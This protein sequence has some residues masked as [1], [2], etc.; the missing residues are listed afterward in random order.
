MPLVRLIGSD[1]ESFDTFDVAEMTDH[2]NHQHSHRNT[3]SSRQSGNGVTAAAAA[4]SRYTTSSTLSPT[5]EADDLTSIDS[6]SGR[7]SEDTDRVGSVAPRGM[8]SGRGQSSSTSV[9]SM[10]SFSVNANDNIP[11]NSQWPLYETIDNLDEME[12]DPRNPFNRS[13]NSAQN[14]NTLRSSWGDHNIPEEEEDETG[15]LSS[16]AEDS[17]V[18]PSLHQFNSQQMNQHQSRHQRNRYR[19]SEN[20]DSSIASYQS[21][22]Q[23]SKRTS[24]SDNSSHVIIQ[25]LESQVAKLNFELATT[26]SSLD[27]LQLEN[28][29]LN[30][31]KDKLT[32]NTT[33]LQEENERLYLTIERLQKEQ[34]IR[35]MQGTKGV[36]RA[37]NS[38]QD[39][40]V[41]WGG[42]TASGNTWFGDGGENQVKVKTQQLGKVEG[43]SLEVPFRSEGR[44]YHLRPRRRSSICSTN[45]FNSM[46]DDTES[47]ASNDCLSAH[48]VALNESHHSGDLEYQLSDT[49]EQDKTEKSGTSLLEMIEDSR[50]R[51]GGGELLGGGEIPS[52]RE[53][54]K[55]MKEAA[56]SLASRDN[57]Q[58]EKGEAETGTHSLP[59]RTWG[60]FISGARREEKIW[61][62]ASGSQELEPIY[63][64][65]LTAGCSAAQHDGLSL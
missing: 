47:R 43:D 22:R 62:A 19:Q 35:H 30:D 42:A 41:V 61:V 56:I 9:T 1:A 14:N 55:R 2:R 20:D 8:M 46:N 51:L 23:D 40:C 60:F 10:N 53:T 63:Y 5:P 24:T 31:D 16:Y 27:E 57:G 59:I 17:S 18:T 25:Q 58:A 29:R 64:G 36:A 6:S 13:Q 12:H 11:H 65:I 32:N 54:A 39:S 34:I 52:A 50:R 49:D 28:R 7:R 48:S 33:L 3:W 37:S 21:H 38:D 45:S 15:S 26:K 44:E 4:K